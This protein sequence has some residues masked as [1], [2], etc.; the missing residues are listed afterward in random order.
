[1]LDRPG[2]WYSSP[3]KWPDAA[4][5]LVST[6][7]DLWAFASMLA[8]GG[9]RLLSAESVRQM[10]RD[11]MTSRDRAESRIFLGDH[12]GWGLMMLVPAADGSTGVPGGFGWEGG[13]GTVW[14]TDPATGL[15][16]ILLTQRMVTSPSRAA[17]RAPDYCP[18]T[19]GTGT[20][21]G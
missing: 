8:S 17:L 12:S 11:R 6:V 9:G 16:G 4:G 15:T 14:R 5:W 19:V 13:S 20:F 21:V 3:P 2:G 7:D 10:T 18:V 1:V